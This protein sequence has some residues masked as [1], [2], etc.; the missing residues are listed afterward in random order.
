[1]KTII[2]AVIVLII[3]T[4]I[5]FLFRRKHIQEIGR[6][7][8]EKLQIQHK[9]ILEEMTK[10]KQLNMTGE[11]EEKF[12]RW[13]TEWTEVMDVHMPKIDS[14][15]FDVEDMV[16]RFRF[17]KA[18][19]TEKE[20]QEQIRFC[21]HKMNAILKELNELVGSEEKNRIEI[22]KLKEQHRAARKTV[23]AHQHSFGM[24]AGPLEKELESFNPKFKEYDE[25]TANGNYLQ[26]REI[27][28]SLSVQGERLFMLIH[29][30][31]SLLTELQNRIPASLRE[32]RMGTKEMEDQSY[33]LQHLEL[34]RQMQDIESEIKEMLA[35]M[36]E[37][38]IEAVQQQTNEINDR[39]DSFYDALEN[40]V[41][42]RHYVDEN[43]M[44]VADLLTDMTELATE[45]SAEASYVQQSYRLDEKEA[46]IPQQSLKKL[47]GIVK[48][49][50]VLTARLEDQGSAYSSLSTELQQIYE[51]LEQ[52]AE[53]Q[54]SFTNRLKNLRIDENNV[55]TK[56]NELSRKLQNA[57]R[58][59]HKG[60]IPGIPDEIEAR[61]EEADEQIY[62]V[63]Q[64]LQ[65]VPLNMKLVD[66]YLDNAAKAVN[67]VSGKVEELL[68]N[69]MLIEWIIQYGNR[70]RAS[71][72]EV[73][74]RLLDAEESF[75]Q[76][77]YAKA[78][79][80]AATAVEEV[81][82]GAMKRIEELVK[83]SV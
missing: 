21:D 28:I 23:L 41:N 50:E 69:V 3:L 61:L 71:N 68:E 82:P 57:D 64:S 12:E 11:T 76:F 42:A 74:T 52:I 49:F 80:E 25:L 70:F 26:A 43:Y 18:T 78:L 27:V 62:I 6:L 72:P 75:R 13:R 14:L 38:Q 36:A 7:E 16:D 65:E 9:P 39:I 53:E 4:T 15:L 48:R 60:N 40:E 10:V 54:E 31:P 20:I 67:D 22:E 51:Q 81:E 73:H 33:Y 58:M 35:K 2:I 66:S 8:K 34:P 46:Q 56:L 32:L 24:T 47:N 44:H 19:G 83:E 55:R 37:L 45:T 5:A 59:L 77:R 17:R 29:E 1:M 30:T 63:T 79:E